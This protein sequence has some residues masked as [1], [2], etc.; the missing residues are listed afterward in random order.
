MPPDTAIN[1]ITERAIRDEFDA[2]RMRPDWTWLAT[3]DAGRLIGRALWWG[4]DETA[5]IALD[6]LDAKGPT[7]SRAEV[8]P[9]LLRAGHGALRARGYPVPLPHTVR[10]PGDWR[11]HPLCVDAV[12]W[13]QRAA[14]G[15]G[16]SQVNERLQYEWTPGVEPPRPR[17]GLDFCPGSDAQFQRLF[18][19]AAVGSLDVLTA[20]TLALSTPEDLGRDEL[21]YYRSCPGEREWWRVAVDPAGDLIGFVIPSATPHSRNVGYLGVLP[22]HRGHGYVDDLLAYATTFQHAAGATRITATTDATNTPMAEAF[23]RHGYRTVEVRL[24]L[25]APRTTTK[26]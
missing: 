9:A 4:R 14:A 22:E 23:D 12:A 25:E 13:R 3:D 18:A 17:M 7:E 15:A 20:R 16:L 26:C 19:E 1:A 11:S 10:L 24:D 21:D 2:W 8:A 5:P 6:V